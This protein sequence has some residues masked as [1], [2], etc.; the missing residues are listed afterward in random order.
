MEFHIL[1]RV[2]EALQSV[3]ATR[4]MIEAAAAAWRVEFEC[5]ENAR[6]AKEAERKRGASGGAH[7]LFTDATRS[8]YALVAA[9]VT[10]ARCYGR[11]GTPD[12]RGP[13]YIVN[14]AVC[15]RHD[16][17]VVVAE[18]LKRLSDAV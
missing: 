9:G 7:A 14:R 17:M 3:G 13:L 6:R 5:I 1:N 4:E 15:D 16:I 10:C 8:E 11:A 18:E 12:P 2:V